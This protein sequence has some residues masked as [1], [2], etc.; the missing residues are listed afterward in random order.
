MFWAVILCFTQFGDS[1]HYK[2]FDKFHDSYTVWVKEYYDKQNAYTGI[3][4]LS[5][6]QRDNRSIMRR[7]HV[8]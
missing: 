1:S 3:I 5:G 8:F 7:K 2:N 4:S 6:V